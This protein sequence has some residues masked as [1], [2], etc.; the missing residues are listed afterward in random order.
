MY[1]PH[2]I[3]VEVIQDNYD[4]TFISIFSDIGGSIGVL[5]GMSCMTIVDGLLMIH[6]KIPKMINHFWIF[7]IF[8]FKLNYVIFTTILNF[9]ALSLLINYFQN[10]CL[11]IKG[12]KL[13]REVWL[14]LKIFFKNYTLFKYLYFHFEKKRQSWNIYNE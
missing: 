10:I 13:V 2:L 12:D 8:L 7:K 1:L 14:N 3:Q 4:D 9:V 6:K 11:Y 5:I